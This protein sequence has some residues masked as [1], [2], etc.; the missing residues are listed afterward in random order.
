MKISIESKKGFLASNDS[1]WFRGIVGE[2]AF[3][4][5]VH[6]AWIEYTLNHP[7]SSGPN[8]SCDLHNQQYGAKQFLDK[9]LNIAETDTPT[10]RLKDRTALISSIK[11]PKRPD[12]LA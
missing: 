5:A 12:A 9:L 6:A 2:P 1:A 11:E 3:H 7:R 10:E 4:A 8:E